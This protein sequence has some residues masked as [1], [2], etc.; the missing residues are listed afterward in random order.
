MGRKQLRPLLTMVFACS[1]A[2]I[3]LGGTASWAET[4]RCIQ[5]SAP[6]ADC[7]TKNPIVQTIEGMSV[8]LVAGVGAAVGAAW[9]AK[10]QKP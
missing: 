1:A 2:G 7:L 10:K 4:N 8:G 3:F 6:S 5:A 9:Q